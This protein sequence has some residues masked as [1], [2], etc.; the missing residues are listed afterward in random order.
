M[1]WST[2]EIVA[3]LAFQIALQRSFAPTVVVRRQRRFRS[4]VGGSQIP[5]L[6]LAVKMALAEERRLGGGDDDLGEAGA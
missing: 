4:C 1:I 3:A 5:T 2:E 6:R